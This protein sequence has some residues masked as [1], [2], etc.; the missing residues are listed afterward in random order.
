MSDYWNTYGQ[1]Q[2]LEDKLLTTHRNYYI[3]L[4][5][6]FD[7]DINSAIEIGAGHGI[8][9]EVFG[10][11]FER[12][13]ATEPNE[14]LFDKL[15]SLTIEKYNHIT[16]KRY[17]CEEVLKYKYKVDFLIFTHSFQYIKPEVIKEVIN[18]NLKDNGHILILLPFVAFEPTND[19]K[20][21]K[22]ILKVIKYILNMDNSDVIFLDTVKKS[23]VLLVQKK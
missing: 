17:N 7:C 5:E 11:I 20:W 16:T 21:R 23:Y 6:K 10:H 8:F 12:Y 2:Y 3:N 4:L 9:T 1:R 19:I 22:V 15:T 18:K 14:V 13:L